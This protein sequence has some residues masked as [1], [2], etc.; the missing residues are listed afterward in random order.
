MD[1]CEMIRKHICEETDGIELKRIYSYSETL[2]HIM[3]FNV[4]EIRIKQSGS[5]EIKV[6]PAS[7][8]NP[9]FYFNDIQIPQKQFES[10]C[11]EIKRRGYAISDDFSMDI[12][13]N[14]TEKEIKNGASSQI[15]CRVEEIIDSSTGDAK[16][17][18]SII[19][20][21]NKNIS[22]S[23][24]PIVTEPISSK[25][26]IDIYERY[27]ENVA[28]TD[29]GVIIGIRKVNGKYFALIVWDPVSYDYYENKRCFESNS[30]FL[31]LSRALK[32]DPTWVSSVVDDD[33]I[34]ANFSFEYHP[35]TTMV[36]RIKNVNGLM[37]FVNIA[38]VAREL[39]FDF[40]THLMNKLEES[41]KINLH[42]ENQ[43]IP[44]ELLKEDENEDEKD[45]ETP[46]EN[47]SEDK[48]A[49]SLHLYDVNVDEP[50]D[51]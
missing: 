9:D 15:H 47:I 30:G 28:P 3:E 26:I 19:E 37:D 21:V 4:K 20:E 46:I 32:V 39:D 33:R 2:K 38:I 16:S 14:V 45:D 36:E 29:I 5:D 22:A 13:T 34:K 12:T 48:L 27:D 8:K 10:V 49:Q 42:Y 43:I 17:F 31:I 51:D 7:N 25:D 6:F 50:W 24:Y 18:D 44:K 40:V 23:Y 11:E 41:A 35:F 1:R